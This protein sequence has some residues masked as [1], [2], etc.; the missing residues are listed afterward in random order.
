MLLQ[1]REVVRLLLHQGGPHHICEGAVR[2][3]H[4]TPQGCLDHSIC[5]SDSLSSARVSW[6][7]NIL[8]YITLERLGLKM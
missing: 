4:H 1:V 8:F 2:A 5:C 3:V 6:L 7:E